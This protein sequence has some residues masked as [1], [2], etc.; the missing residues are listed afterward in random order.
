MGREGKVRESDS[1]GERES[2]DFFFE[3]GADMEGFKNQNGRTEWRL[4]PLLE[5]FLRCNALVHYNCVMHWCFQFGRLIGTIVLRGIFEDTPNLTSLSFTMCFLSI[6]SSVFFSPQ[7]ILYSPV[8]SM[9]VLSQVLMLEL[10]LRYS[11]SCCC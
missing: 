11:Q 7:F 4:V 9:A 10:V 5:L 8:L 2:S 6:P 3:V 1:S